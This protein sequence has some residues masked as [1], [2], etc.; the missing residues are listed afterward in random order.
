[1]NGAWFGLH[2]SR[3]P[4]V[5]STNASA[6]LHSP[7]AI[8][9]GV[10][11]SHVAPPSAVWA[12]T[13]TL[14]IWH[15]VAGEPIIAIQPSRSSTNEMRG[16]AVPKFGGSGFSAQVVPRSD[17]R[18]RRVPATKAQITSPEG[19]L[20]CVKLGSAIGVGEGDA[21]GGAAEDTGDGTVDAVVDAPGVPTC[22]DPAQAEAPSNRMSTVMKRYIGTSFSGKAR[23]RIR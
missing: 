12:M 13:P 11:D 3:K 5:G 22:A 16:F 8:P 17:E 2:A 23:T 1:M 4:R 21:A 6:S 15:C 10:S 9:L 14:W 7:S 20:N 19:T 18:K